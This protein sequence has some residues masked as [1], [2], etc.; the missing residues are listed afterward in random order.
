MNTLL[1]SIGKRKTAHAIVM[2][3]KGHGYIEINNKQSSN[4]F[5]SLLINITDLEIPF[6][7][8]Q[9]QSVY[10]VKAYVTGSGILSQFHAIKLAIAK[11]V[12]SINPVFKKILRQ[13]NLIT[14]DSRNKERKKYG[15]K[16]ARKASQYSKR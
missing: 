9:T 10:D 16:K 13:N 14:T 8:T 5:N 4:Y 7:L 6:I 1:N 15:L 3:K 2:L 11:A 12:A